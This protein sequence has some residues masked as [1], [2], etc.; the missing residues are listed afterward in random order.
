L[1]RAGVIKVIRSPGPC[2]LSIIVPAF[3]EAEGL[4]ANLGVIAAAARETSL[5]FDLIVVDDGSTDGTWAGLQALAGE[6]P[7]L[8]AVRLSRNFG[9]E[10]AICAGLDRARGDAC[11]VLDADLQHPPSLIPEMVRLW[12]DERWDVVEAV[13]QRRG[14]ESR[15]QRSMARAFYGIWARLTGQDLRNASDFKLLDRRVVAEWQRLGERVTFFRGLVT[16]FGFRRTHVFFDVPARKTGRSAWSFTR[17]GQLA[18]R[19]VTSFSALPLQMVTGL[20]VVTLVLAA[21]LGAQAVR[22]WL[23]GDALPGFTTVILLQL[24]IGGFLMVSLGIIGTYIA[25]IYDEVKGRPRYIVS[26]ELRA[27]DVEPV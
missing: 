25:R 10:A 14:V 3:Q 22:Q 13:K 9:K 21:V 24:I 17:L 20:G 8:A 4:A 18:V 5:P 7:E 12:R 1:I 15:V 23:R 26:E 6:L 11:I 16:W 27:S 19:A 2:R